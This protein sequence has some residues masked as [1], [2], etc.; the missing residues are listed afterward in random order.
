M[1]QAARAEDMASRL[2]RV[3]GLDVDAGLAFVGNN[4]DVY[5]RLL[6]RFVQLHEPD[7]SEIVRQVQ[8]ADLSAVQQMAHSIKGGAATLGL[9]ALA[10]RAQQIEQAARE[11]GPHER[12]P[13]LAAALQTDYTTLSRHLAK[14]A[15]EK[16]AGSGAEP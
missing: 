5:T 4:V 12:L 9:T 14:A 7:V 13:E 15:G 1:D 16:P 2:R 3:A 8:C 6:A 10:S 11:D